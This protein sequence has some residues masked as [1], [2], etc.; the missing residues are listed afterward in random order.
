MNNLKLL[1]EEKGI[2]QN[3]LIEELEKAPYNLKISRRTLQYWESNKRDIKTDKAEKLAE[4]FG[5][6]VGYL[7]GYSDETQKYFETL[8]LD[9]ILKKE[10]EEVFIDFV[11][12]LKN[13]DIR[14]TNYKIIILF[15]FMISIDENRGD[16]FVL[17]L[18]SGFDGEYSFIDED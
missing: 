6:P 12:F 9:E 18:S 2:S 17:N 14:L 16:N 11:T 10:T 7:L 3:V 15:N 13:N 4:Y 8:E 5:V 1:R